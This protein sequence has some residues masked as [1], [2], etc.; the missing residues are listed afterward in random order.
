[1]AVFKGISLSGNISGAVAV[2]LATYTT[3]ITGTEVDA[4]KAGIMVSFW[5]LTG[6]LANA[7]AA[8]TMTFTVT[9]CATSGGSFTAVA[10]AQYITIDSWDRIIDDSSISNTLYRFDFLL[11][12]GYPYLKLAGT[13]AGTFNDP[14]AAWC[15]FIPEK[16]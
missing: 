10:D 16:K 1:M 12:P 11:A 5:F 9:Q 2:P 15:V 7:S 6:T 8:N 3:T 4:R 13:E 14:L